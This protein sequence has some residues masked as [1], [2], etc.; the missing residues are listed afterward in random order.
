MHNFYIIT[1]CYNYKEVFQRY[2]HSFYSSFIEAKNKLGLEKLPIF[3]IYLV[4]DDPTIPDYF[5]SD[6]VYRYV[7]TM[8]DFENIKFHILRNGKNMGVTYSRNKA[9][10]EVLSNGAWDSD[11]LLHFDVDDV[12][13]NDSVERLTEFINSE[14]NNDL[15]FSTHELD[16]SEKLKTSNQVNYAHINLPESMTLDRFTSYCPMPESIYLWRIDLV[17]S[18]WNEFGCLWYM[19][20]SGCK[21]FSEDIMFLLH[22]N[23]T[24]VRF[25]GSLC[26]AD[27]RHGNYT[28]DFRNV[29]YHNKPSFRVLAILRQIQ[30]K[31]LGREN[32]SKDLLDYVDHLSYM[33]LPTNYDKLNEN[34][35]NI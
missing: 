4:D 28:R 30:I 27:Y 33:T 12:W 7:H 3:N 25:N 19:D 34:C 11:F 23:H 16:T 31:R 8:G 6:I 24:I 35:Y 15:Y 10:H 9:V 14:P 26:K 29:I 32:L 18:I 13:T 21:L 20:G 5:I 2:V 1:A 22:Y 17:K